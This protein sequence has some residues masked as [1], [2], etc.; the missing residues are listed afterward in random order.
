MASAAPMT[1]SS[2]HSWSQARHANLVNMYNAFAGSAF[3]I[4]GRKLVIS[5]SK[6]FGRDDGVKTS[7]EV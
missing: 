4:D 3:R 7:I 2:S 1:R 6:M 5:E